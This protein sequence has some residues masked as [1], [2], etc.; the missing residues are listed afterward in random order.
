MHKRRTAVLRRTGAFCG[1]VAAVW[2]LAHA[3]G[4][5][6]PG[7]D[8]SVRA[9]PANSEPALVTNA[10]GGELAIRAGERTILIVEAL[11]PDITADGTFEP[12][13]LTVGV[14]P[15]SAPAMPAWLGE[16]IWTSGPS[17]QPR[18]VLTFAPPAD[19][20]PGR[21][22]IE[23]GATDA[24]GLTV[25]KTVTL[26]VL[27][28][29]CG[30]LE[31][32]ADG[33]CRTCPD[34]EVPDASGTGCAP[35][36]AGTE[37]PAG[38]SAC[39]DCAAGLTSMAGTA[40]G[41]GFAQRLQDGVCVDCPPHTESVASDNACVACPADT[42]RPA[43]TETCTDCPV[44]ATSPGGVACAAAAVKGDVADGLARK[45]S[46]A[47][48]TVAPTIS[49]AVYAG[50]TVTLGMSEPVW[51]ETAPAVGD[52]VLSVTDDGSPVTSTV[53]AV[54]V[55]SLAAQA[56]DTITLTLS[57]ALGGSATVSLTYT[58]NADAMQ[59]PR[60]A[61]GNRL[62]TQTVTVAALRT[63]TVSFG[64]LT[65]GEVPEDAGRVR[66]T[67]VLSNPPDS[68]A[69]TGCGLRLVSGSVA[70]SD[71][72]K[73]INADK[74]LRPRNNWSTTN[75]LLQ[76]ADDTLAEGDEA[77]IVEAYCTGGDAGM[78]PAAAN[79][80]SVPVELTL[81][82]DESRTVTLTVDP[83]KIEETAA[84][85]AVTVTA[86]LDGEATAELALSLSLAGT[87]TASDYMV[88][89]TQSVSIA[90]GARSGTTVLTVT[91][92]AD[93]DDLDETIAIASTLTGY[94]VTGT[95]VTIAE[96]RV[97]SIVSSLVNAD[98][99]TL[100]EDAGS[101]NV[102][103][104]LD[105]K[106]AQ[107]TYT[108]C[109]VRL[110]T[111]SVAESPADV[112]FAHQKKLNAG[113]D[114]TAQTGFLTV[115]DDTLVED[116][117]TLILEG[118]CGGSKNQADPPHT[119]LVSRPLT[120]TLQD[121]DQP[122]PLTLSVAPDTIHETLGEQ[123]VTVTVT[124]DSGP[125][126]DVTVSLNLATGSY[127]VTGTQSITIAAGSTSGTTDLAF[128]PSDDSNTTD[129]TVSIRGTATGYT[130][131]ETNLTIKEPNEVGGVDVSGLGVALSVSPTGVQEGTSGPHTVTATLTGVSVPT[132]DVA[133]VLGIGGTAT[134]GASHDYTLT[135]TGA[136][137]WK[138]LTVEA[139]DAHLTADTSV[140]VSALT[141]TVEEG[142][143]TVTFTVSQ[144]T[145]R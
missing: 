54:T 29:L 141:D 80:V 39:V 134:E 90:A 47:A 72:V 145:V 58:A 137:D 107:G 14:S 92:A 40:C 131:T 18:L 112:T 110:V 3:S 26:S 24:R 114:W 34:H 78:E 20:A 45:S 82:D 8:A 69:Y 15:G 23:A 113:N 132:V 102:R 22:A 115:V 48:D 84:A 121:N 94:T 76:V 33:V 56:S 91:P 143:E 93:D 142:E 57:S 41:C 136:S 51:A 129:D 68:G 13:W 42:Q 108:G 87:A 119:D 125:A 25:L 16:T 38:S 46:S 122:Q 138:E 73:F 105:P 27:P 43:G 67:L 95:T 19:A 98:S 55:A 36:P 9:M 75:R 127:T 104:T 118:Y 59:R 106:P 144:V 109:Q 60:D 28:P 126:A 66:A 123:T 124:A 21:Y 6:E 116:D 37:R 53:T 77:L 79:L 61:A 17:V 4:A 81:V 111:G 32:A 62:A 140:R 49:S 135:G 44:G 31:F 74:R 85:T 89:G 7:A 2:A 101:V 50:D 12:V 139:N 97:V 1:L 128:T 88:T 10:R 5:P 35:C 130:V 52:F 117:E 11:D 103:L 86:T 30:A 99:T 70:D 96:P 63:L 71:D 64:E 83:E 65:N 133:F 100:S 120:L